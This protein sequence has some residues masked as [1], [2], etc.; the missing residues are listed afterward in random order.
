[1]TGMILMTAG[2]ATLALQPAASWTAL[3]VIGG[4]IGTGMGLSTVPLLIAVQTLI[5]PEQRGIATT[6]ILFFRNIGGTL[7]V[8]V[9]GATLTARLGVEVAGLAEGARVLP[10]S[11]A[12]GLVAGMG[13]VFWLGTAATGLGLAAAGFLPRSSPASARAAAEELLG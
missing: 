9:M 13:V 12:A 3:M 1:M 7:G 8:A 6:G 2:Y 5:R 10:P 11:L 4:T